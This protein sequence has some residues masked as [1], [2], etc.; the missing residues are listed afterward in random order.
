MWYL[1]K[2]VGGLNHTKKTKLNDISLFYFKMFE[3]NI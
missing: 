3:I 2:R 1:K